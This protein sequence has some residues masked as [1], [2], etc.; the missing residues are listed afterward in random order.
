MQTSTMITANN[1]NHSIWII[2]YFYEKTVKLAEL[3]DGSERQTYVDNLKTG[4][5][6]MTQSDT[7]V[8]KKDYL[9]MIIMMLRR[10]DEL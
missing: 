9:Y 8:V 4:L 2:F 5:I 10:R 6:Q 7:M 3:P 1:P